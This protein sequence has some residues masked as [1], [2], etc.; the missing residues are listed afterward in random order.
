MAVRA[1][2]SQRHYFAKYKRRHFYISLHMPGGHF[3]CPTKPGGGRTT[4]ATHLSHVTHV[5]TETSVVR[6][7]DAGRWPGACY[8][9]SSYDA[10]LPHGGTVCQPRPALHHCQMLLIIQGKASSCVGGPGRRSCGKELSVD[11]SRIPGK[12]VSRVQEKGLFAYT[13]IDLLK[14]H[15]LL[16][17]S[18]S[19]RTDFQFC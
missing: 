13:K 6:A 17:I 4:D 5:E 7:K 19:A 2:F 16:Q 10:P 8:P 14:C 9:E 18:N 11:D 15:L 12:V 3:Y 1:A